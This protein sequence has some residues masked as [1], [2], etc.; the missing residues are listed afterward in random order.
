MCIE[1]RLSQ[2]LVLCAY[3]GTQDPTNPYIA[4]WSSG[5]V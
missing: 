5:D 1:C 4:E 3:S 2:T